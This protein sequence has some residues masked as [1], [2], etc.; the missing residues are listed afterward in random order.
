MNLSCEQKI[1]IVNISIGGNSMVLNGANWKKI[2]TTEICKVFEKLTSVCF[3][4]IVQETMLLLINNR[5]YMKN[6]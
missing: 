3:F 6:I 1:I 5:V 4:Q 2:C